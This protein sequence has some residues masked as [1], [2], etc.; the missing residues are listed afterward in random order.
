MRKFNK[1]GFTLVELIVVIAIIGV[2]AA[3]LIPTMIGYVV[4]AHVANINSTAGK[5]RDCASYFMTN[6]SVDGFGMFRSSKAICDVTV[7]IVDKE[8]TVTTSTQD[9][10]LKEYVT[11]WKQT[12]TATIEN[13]YDVNNAEARFAHYFAETFRDVE[14]GYGKFRLV[15]G[16]CKALYFTDEQSTEI[17]GMPEFGEA[18]DWVID[19]FEWG[20]E[21][22][23]VMKSGLI[24]GTSPIIG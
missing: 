3:I 14:K 4:R 9:C 2:L 1:K 12:G 11:E 5:M 17:E 20:T 8:W 6:A 18:S 13:D 24:V 7:V 21:D 19:G 10:F 23:G 15:G 16:Y 22:S